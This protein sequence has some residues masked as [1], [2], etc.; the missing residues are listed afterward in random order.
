MRIAELR[1]EISKTI[2]SLHRNGFLS[3]ARRLIRVRTLLDRLDPAKVVEPRIQSSLRE[4]L[5]MA[6]KCGSEDTCS[7]VVS[8][9]HRLI[10][11]IY[12]ENAGEMKCVVRARKLFYLGAS[13]GLPL[14][15][16]Y[17]TGPLPIMVIFFTLIVTYFQVVKLTRLG[18]ATVYTVS[19]LI[20]FFDALTL[21]YSLYALSTPAEIAE[22]ARTLGIGIEIALVLVALLLATASISMLCLLYTITTFTRLREVFL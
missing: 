1:D 2:F 9:I 4:L 19:T 7:D 22:I 6:R 14:I 13:L 3:A 16:L 11:F 10:M 20:L 12:L 15:A 8:R 5:S 18:L 21:R 17:G